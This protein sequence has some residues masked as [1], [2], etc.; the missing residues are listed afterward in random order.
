MACNTVNFA[1]VMG[2]GNNEKQRK[3]GL[4]ADV[5]FTRAT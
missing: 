4:L 1:G 3:Y 5:A 2:D